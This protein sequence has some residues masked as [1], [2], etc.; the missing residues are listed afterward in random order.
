MDSIIISDNRIEVE[1]VLKPHTRSTILIPFAF[2]QN[3]QIRKPETIHGN[4]LPSQAAV[5][6]ASQIFNLKIVAII[7][8]N[9]TILKPFC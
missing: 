7:F 6:E 5:I 2:N 8:Y 4:T 1:E 3:L 9:K